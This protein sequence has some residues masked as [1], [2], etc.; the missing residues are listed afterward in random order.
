MPVDQIVT[1]NPD[2]AVGCSDSEKVMPRT[3]PQ[4]AKIIVPNDSTSL[5][6]GPP[7]INPASPLEVPKLGVVGHR[8]RIF[9]NIL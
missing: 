9:T 3:V 1:P 7:R 4:M 2:E 8:G 5:A 6:I